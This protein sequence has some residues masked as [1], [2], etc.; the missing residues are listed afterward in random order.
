[1]YKLLV[2]LK[3]GTPNERTLTF[4]IDDYSVENGF[5]KFFDKKEQMER[6]FPQVLCEMKKLD[7]ETDD[8]RINPKS[9][10]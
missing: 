5:I 6:Y 7:D 3:A 4:I 10:N 1:M 9:Q 2:T 8:R